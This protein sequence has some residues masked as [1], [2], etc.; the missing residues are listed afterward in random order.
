MSWSRCDPAR[1][2]ALD[3]TNLG[4]GPRVVLVHGSVV[5]ADVT[6]RHQ[7]ALAERYTLV[8]AQ[9]PG[10]GASPPLER[11]DFEAEAPLFAELLEGGAHMVG[12]SYGAVIAL[13]AAALRPN[14]VLSLTISEPGAAA[15]RGRRPSGRLDDRQRR[16][17]LPPRGRARADRLP[18]LLPWRGE[19]RARD[20]RGARRPA[21]RWRAD[22]HARTAALGVRA[23]PRRAGRRRV[24]QARDL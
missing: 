22:G 14:A 5:G 6:W 17:A 16:R 19:L 20:A 8:L 21:A 12:H 7:H 11:G 24:S 13:H 10:F 1:I 18:A 2:A 9:R 15:R 4:S 23:A 3:V